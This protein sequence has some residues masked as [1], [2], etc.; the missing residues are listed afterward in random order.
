LLK[1]FTPTL[2]LISS[3]VVISTFAPTSIPTLAST[4]FPTFTPTLT[5]P[6]VSAPALAEPILL[7]TPKIAAALSPATYILTEP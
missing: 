3:A 4:F 1:E 2:N 5:T 6:I 7:L